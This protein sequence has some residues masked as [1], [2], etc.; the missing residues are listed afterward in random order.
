[1]ASYT[2]KTQIL[3]ALLF[4][5]KLNSGK[6]E[7]G[8][9]LGPSFTNITNSESDYR[10]AL[11]LGMFFNIRPDKKFHIHAEL[12]PKA[13]FGAKN[14]SPYSLENDSLDHL[15]STGSVERIIRTMNM[16]ILGRYTVSKHFFIDAGIQ[17]DIL[18]KPRDIFTVS[19]GDDE[20]QY[21]KK[22]DEQFTRLDFQL[23]GGF[24]YRFKPDIGGMGLGF[25]YTRGL[26]DI[27]KHAAGSQVNVAWQFHI[28][29]PIGAQA[30]E[31]SKE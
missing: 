10:S 26:T 8:L 30:K 14:I 21:T 17:P 19:I 20:L 4:G 2:A 27:D 7:F 12:V 22:L 3:I 23:A 18:Y 24:F 13:S 16:S 28:T 29:I 31:K 25:R 5:E 15:F 11:T 6:P 9:V 1:M